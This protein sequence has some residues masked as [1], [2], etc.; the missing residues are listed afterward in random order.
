MSM[1]HQKSNTVYSQKTL[2]SPNAVA[3]FLFLFW[4]IFLNMQVGIAVVGCWLGDSSYAN[5]HNM[6]FV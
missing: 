4:G 5:V 6:Y 2:L 3:L 1:H